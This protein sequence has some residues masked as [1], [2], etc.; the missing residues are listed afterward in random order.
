MPRWLALLE[1]PQTLGKGTKFWAPFVLVLVAASA[2]P[3]FADGYDV[4]NNVYFFN[5]AFM[6]LGLSLIWGYGGALSFGQ[7]AF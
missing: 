2:Y 3:L 1:G 7:T 4:G 5:W 6:A